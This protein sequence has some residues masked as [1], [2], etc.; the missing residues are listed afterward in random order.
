MVNNLHTASFNSTGL[1]QEIVQ[2]I[3][4]GILRVQSV[5]I[6]LIQEA[7][8]LKKCMSQLNSIHDSY[9]GDG[10]SGIDEEATILQGRR[11]GGVGF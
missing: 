10:V 1:N 6:L 4:H 3:K 5:D 7:W 2:F 11:Y 9:L 8:L